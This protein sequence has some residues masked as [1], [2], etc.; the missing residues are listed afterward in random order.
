MPSKVDTKTWK[1]FLELPLLN[2]P[3]LFEDIVE[4]GIAFEPIKKVENGW[5][6]GQ[7]EIKKKERQGFGYYVY[8]DGALYA[9]MWKD[10][11]RHGYGRIVFS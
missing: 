4:S 7:W 11:M 5:Y 2:P 8:E 6:L 1:K 10:D 3:A 9:G